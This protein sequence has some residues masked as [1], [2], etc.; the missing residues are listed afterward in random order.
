MKE[1][2]KLAEESFSETKQS[3]TPVSSMVF[4]KEASNALYIAKENNFHLNIDNVDE[5]TRKSSRNN[6]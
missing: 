1:Y 2:N 5:E 6:I 3:F 4:P